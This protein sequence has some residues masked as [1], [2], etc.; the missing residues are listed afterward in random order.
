MAFINY[1][2]LVVMAAAVAAPLLAQT[3]AGARVPVVV[4]EVLLGVLL[5]PHA[6]G[7][8]QLDPFLTTMVG[9]GMAA[10][11]FMAGM[12]I[13]FDRIRGRPLSLA[14]LGWTLSVAVAFLAVALLHVIPGVRAPTMVTLAVTT[15]GLGVVLPILAD[16]GRL[17]TPFGRMA[18]AAGT[19]GEVAPTVAAAV[20][21]STRYTSVQEFAFLIVFIGLVA[22][23][24][25]AGLR[26]RPP[27]LVALL[28]R[29]MHGSSQL[30]LRL[31]L[32]LLVVFFVVSEEFGL[33]GIL[34][35]FAAGMVVKLAT[36]GEPGK[37]IRVKIDAVCFGWLTPFF[38]VGTGLQFDLASLTRSATTLILAPTFL[39]LFLLARGLPV[40]LYRKEMARREMAPFALSSSVASLGLV[41]VIVQIGLR[42]GSMDADVGGALI[43]AAL[44]SM[45]VFPTLASVL[46]ARVGPARG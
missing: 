11:L 28:D 30:P 22:M 10:V 32:L 46:L 44:L 13:D 6:L 3:R 12:E 26:A 9:F 34:G 21:L 19:V 31:T 40:F 37:V 4:L 16:G 5:G 7:L 35:A 24:A 20:V 36:S 42:A 17:Q 23:A 38:F 27:R 1:P 39:A 25:T 15:T 29:T 43:A 45:L 8:V 2:V 18:L 33:E 14:L 41:A